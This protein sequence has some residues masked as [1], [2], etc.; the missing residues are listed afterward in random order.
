[1]VVLSVFNGF[2]DLA[3][4]HLSR[5]DPEVKVVPASGS[6]LMDVDSL[7]EVLERL[8]EVRVA[9]PT[10]EQRGLLISDSQTPTQTPVRFKGVTERYNLVT[11]IDSVTIDGVFSPEGMYGYPGIQLSV[12]SAMSSGMR[13][14]PGMSLGMLYVP[15]RMG[16]I[17]PAN[18]A[19]AYM[20]QRL[21]TTGV[22]R[23]NQPEYDT[24]YVL[25]PLDVARSLLSYTGT[26]AS[27]IELSLT[28][29]SSIPEKAIRAVC[30]EVRVLN[31]QR[32]QANAF[33]MIEIEKWVTFMMLIF[34]LL[35]ASFNI[36]STLSLLVIEKRDDMRTLRALG[37]SRTR[38]RRIFAL[39]GWLITVIGGICGVA[40]GVAL[41]LLQQHSGLVKLNADASTLSITAYPVRVAAADVALVLAS[42][43]VVGLLISQ[44]TRIFVSKN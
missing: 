20:G 29:G 30:G 8:P 28:P 38:I 6:V 5:I 25:I 7:C 39:E 17:N 2:A 33:R 14:Q 12:G 9:V 23:V 43:A 10:L 26:E 41:G 31:R 3:A 44:I 13:P 27:A 18:P 21:S 19:A 40:T 36:I 37:A 34:I 24:D 35:V 22:F 1:M 32:Q 15:R 4:G 11:D 42:V 16:R